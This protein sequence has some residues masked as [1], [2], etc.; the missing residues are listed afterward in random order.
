MGA[1][2][3]GRLQE[4]NYLLTGLDFLIILLVTI[5]AAWMV[6]IFIHVRTKPP[7]IR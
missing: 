4:L 5:I 1:L 6:A 2:L 7:R 3:P